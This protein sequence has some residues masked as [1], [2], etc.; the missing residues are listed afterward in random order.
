MKQFD[1]AQSI[2]IAAN[3]GVIIGIVFLG[4]EIH[5]NTIA[6]EA[7]SLQIAAELDQSFLIEVG[8][9]IETSRVWTTYVS[10]PSTLTDAER[11]QGTLLFGAL[12][13]RLEN[14]RLQYES[15]ALSEDGWQSRQA[16]FVGIAGTP[17][18][19][20]FRKSPSAQLFNKAIVDYLDQLRASQQ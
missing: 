1:L 17:G 6:T 7:A 12:V 3:I 9:D 16:L 8:S 13:R 18:Y 20:E 14:V 4:V 11:G 19:A 15:G 2:T 5:G 10:A